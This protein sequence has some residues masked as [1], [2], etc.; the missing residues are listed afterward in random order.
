MSITDVSFPIISQ[1]SLQMYF[2]QRNCNALLDRI[3]RVSDGSPEID[4]IVWTTI[5][6]NFLVAA[7][8]RHPEHLGQCFSL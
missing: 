7:T 5:R 4:Q 2:V 6:L 1:I 8:L 3:N